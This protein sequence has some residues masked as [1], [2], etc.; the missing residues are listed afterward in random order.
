M[1]ATKSQIAHNMAMPSKLSMSYYIATKT[2]YKKKAKMD[3]NLKCLH[4]QINKFD[5]YHNDIHTIQG[6]MNQRAVITT[7]SIF[8]IILTTSVARVRAL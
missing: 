7:S 8:R 5:N 2:T 4:D 3:C 1:A 6:R